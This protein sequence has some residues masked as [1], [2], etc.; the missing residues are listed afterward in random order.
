MKNKLSKILAIV[1]VITMIWANI[2]Y[3]VK[4]VE[5]GGNQESETTENTEGNTG[6]GQ[7]TTE[8]PKEP[9]IPETPTKEETPE[10]AQPTNSSSS[11]QQTTTTSTKTKATTQSKSDNANLSNLGIRPNDFTGFTPSQ[12]TYNVT[13]PNDVDS[14]EVYAT[15]QNAN[16]TISGTGTKSLQEGSNALMVT[17]TAQNGTKKTYTINVTRQT[18]E[19]SEENSEEANATEQAEGLEKVEIAG[20]TLSPEFQT[21]IY[22]YTA[23]YIGEETNLNVD[24]VATNSDYTVEVTGNNDLKEGENLITILVTDAKGEN[25]ATYQITLN[26][27]LVD[28]EALAREQEELERQENQRKMI[29][30]GIAIIFVIIVIVVII[31]IKRRKNRMLAEDYSGIPFSGLNDDEY[32][33]NYYENYLE[34]EEEGPGPLEDFDQ[35]MNY[36]A[37]ENIGKQDELDENDIEQIEPT[38][39]AKAKIREEFLNNYKFDDYDEKEM[40]KRKNKGKRFK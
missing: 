16:A 12:T 36:Q 33:D 28:E 7:T 5:E 2:C 23:K 11:S 32:D 13:V 34:G 6:G 20:A 31:I 17:V 15:A 4:A 39:D 3:Q 22:E 40:P 29:A 9:E 26:K 8:E 30:A 37:N 27:S 14:V 38:D 21:N 35:N 1:I 10:P 25:V 24:A 19:E 18:S